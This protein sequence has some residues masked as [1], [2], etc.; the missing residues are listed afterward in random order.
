VAG[1][2]LTFGMEETFAAYLARG[3]LRSVLEAFSPSF[4]G[5]YLYFPQRKNL[6]PA[7]RA[8]VEHVR[9]PARKRARVTRR[10]NNLGARPVRAR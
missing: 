6:A 10:K 3:E 4:A 2:G 9:M 1:A 5:F 8:L 7:L